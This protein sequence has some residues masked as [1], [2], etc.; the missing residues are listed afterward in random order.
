M[1]VDPAFTTGHHIAL[2]VE[3]LIRPLGSDGFILK[4]QNGVISFEVGALF[5][6]SLEDSW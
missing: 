1:H 3:L 6:L 2:V 5:H 4:L